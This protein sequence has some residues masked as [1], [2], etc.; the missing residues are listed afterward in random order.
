LL[1]INGLE[2][3]SDKL[4][5]INPWEGMDSIEVIYINHR[6]GVLA[7]DISPDGRWIALNY[8]I[9]DYEE[10]K[11]QCYIGYISSDAGEQEIKEFFPPLEE[12]CNCW[13]A[14][15]SPDGEW[16]AFV[17]EMEN[18]EGETDIFIYP[19]EPNE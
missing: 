18:V 16:I 10:K 3:Y 13:D 7:T 19:F 9:Y 6:F 8:Y 17:S 5:K 14:S 2:P 4:N 1:Y 11:L 15:F 12:G